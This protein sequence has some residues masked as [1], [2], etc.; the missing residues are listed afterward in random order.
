MSKRRPPT[1]CLVINAS[2]AFVA[3]SLESKD[4]TARRCGDFLVALRGL[5]Y[6]MAWNRAI[7]AEWDRH[8]SRFA[9]AWLVTMANLGK[10][11]PVTDEPLEELRQAIGD[12]SRDRGVKRNMVKDAHLVEAAFASDSRIASLDENAR[13][14]FRRLA[15]TYVTLRRIHWVNP[16]VEAE[17]VVAW[18]E[19]GARLERSRYLRP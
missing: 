15:A 8:E 1:C 16:A 9:A 2:V 6:R 11:R 17:Q 14:H 19:D 7:K 10:L 12:H 13:G 3:Q 4:P 5:G 18:L